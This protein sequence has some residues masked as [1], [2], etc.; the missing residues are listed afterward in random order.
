[1]KLFLSIFLA[2]ISITSHSQFKA[3]DQSEFDIDPPKDI[4]AYEIYFKPI[5]ANRPNL[6]LRVE[7]ENGLKK[8]TTEMKDGRVKSIQYNFYKD[9]LLQKSVIKHNNPKSTETWYYKYDPLTHE[10]IYA[11]AYNNNKLIYSYTK[12]QNN[13][14]IEI[15]EMFDD[16]WHKSNDTT[17]IILTNDESTETSIFHTNNGVSPRYT[18]KNYTSNHNLKN[19]I[20]SSTEQR[21]LIEYD[22]LGRVEKRINSSKYGTFPYT[23]FYTYDSIGRVKKETIISDGISQRIIEHR[24]SNVEHLAICYLIINDKHDT[25]ICW[26]TIIKFDNKGNEISKEEIKY[27]DAFPQPWIVER[28]LSE[29]TYRNNRVVK[30]ERTIDLDNRILKE[31]YVVNYYSTLTTTHQ[32]K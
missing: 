9:T 23:F 25:T 32:K 7:V 20:D 29:K 28:I 18:I 19:Q 12:N 31:T 3:S 13:N 8:K 5:N 24:Y 11:K 1:M 4:S 6:I 10:Q 22:S 14:I 30:F 2:L 16:W 15:K 26:K 17:S 27:N 21:E